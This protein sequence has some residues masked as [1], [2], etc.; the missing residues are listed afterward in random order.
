VFNLTSGG[1]TIDANT[2]LLALL[3]DPVA[4]SVSPQLH[5][6]LIK[7]LN[8]DCRYL[9]FR[10]APGDLP[11]AVAGLRVL[12]TAGFN[13][14]IP[15]KQAIIPLLDEL[16]Q[17]AQALEAVNTVVRQGKKLIGHNTDWIGFLQPLAGQTLAGKHAVVLGAGGAA[18]AVVYA[19]A[20]RGMGQIS[21]VNRTLKNAEALVTQAKT[22]FGFTKI[23]AFAADA[24]ALPDLLAGAQLLVNSTS[25]GMWPHVEQSPLDAA[26]LHKDLTVY[27]LV[28][29]PLNTRLLAAAKSLGAVCIDG[30]D[31][32]I[33]QGAAAFTLWTKA[34]VSK[35]HISRLRPLLAAALPTNEG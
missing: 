25:V 29:N 18:K 27:D 24:G 17:Q 13:L 2:R 4:Q 31:M 10:V 35:V 14:T 19:L 3:G 16:S 7:Y 33:G 15:H 6:C 8:Q 26:L 12:G 1:Q 22:T 34:A 30:L 9:A 20:Q 23:E 32:L 5:N 21:V 28:Y 11:Q